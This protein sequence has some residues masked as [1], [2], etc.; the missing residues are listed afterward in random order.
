MS[1]LVYLETEAWSRVRLIENDRGD[2]AG[3][4]GTVGGRTS[5][6]IH[7]VL[8]RNGDRNVA[9]SDCFFKYG[10]LEENI[11]LG[12]MESLE[13]CMRSYALIRRSAKMIVPLYDPEVFE[14]HP[15]GKIP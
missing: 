12:V 2:P 13:E 10:N 3:H 14:R 15:A 1:V 8:H 9:I 4:P 6:F 7:G 11:P 5:P